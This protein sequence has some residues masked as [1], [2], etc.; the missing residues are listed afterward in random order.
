MGVENIKIDYKRKLVVAQTSDDKFQVM[1][2]GIEANQH[3]R[4]MLRAAEKF[5]HIKLAQTRPTP[6][7]K[8]PPTE[9]GEPKKE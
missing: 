6:A 1:L 5:L 2:E 3:L 4:P 7:I 9:T 8:V